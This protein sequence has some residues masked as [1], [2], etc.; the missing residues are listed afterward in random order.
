M[1]GGYVLLHIPGHP[2]ANRRGYILEH[3]LV[4]EEHLG[5]PLR[6]FETPHH[7]NG[8]RDDNSLSNLELWTKPQPAGQR[9]EDLVDWVVEHYPEYVKAA[10]EGKPQLFA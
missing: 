9:P 7:K 2:S 10:I 1:A 8:R 4:M 5:R 6:P 3:R